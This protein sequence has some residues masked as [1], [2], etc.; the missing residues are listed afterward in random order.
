MNRRFSRRTTPRVVNGKVQKKD[1]HSITARE[2]YVVDRVRPYTGFK[3]VINK[4]EVHDF[5]E[6]I[7]DWDEIGVGIESII[8]DEGGDG[9]DGLY[10]HFTHENTGVIYLS[11]WPREMWV[12]FNEEYFQEHKWLFEIFGVTFEEKQDN[13][14]CFFTEKQAKAFMLLHIFLHEL[15]H[16]VDKLRSKKQNDMRGGEEFAEKYAIDKFSEIWP[17]YVNVFG[18][19][20]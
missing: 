6:L 15:G 13:W 19:P 4:K 2:K 1:N 10:R 16:H 20:Y 18:E 8:L 14:C 3:H 9:F 12:E 11:A 5:I 17:L 7:P